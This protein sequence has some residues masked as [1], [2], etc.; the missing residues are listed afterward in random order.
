[1]SDVFFGT[2]LFV[3]NIT[4]DPVKRDKVLAERGLDFAQ[5][6][7]VFAG[8]VAEV[9]DTRRDYGEK[10]FI[11]AGTDGARIVVIVWTPRDGSRRVISMRYA[12]GNEETLW[13]SLI[14]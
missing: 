8:P 9:E 5:A 12:H 2:T 3:V 10:R 4:F 6:G 14:G 1:L 11:T 13:R 7:A